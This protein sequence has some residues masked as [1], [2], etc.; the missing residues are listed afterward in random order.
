MRLIIVS[1]LSG[2]GKSVALSTLEDAGFYCIDNLPPSL[3]KD[4]AQKIGA[5]PFDT[6]ERIAVGIDA[7]SEA[8]DLR[9]LP[10]LLDQLSTGPLSTELLFLETDTSVLLRRFNETRRRHPLTR[11]GVALVEAIEMERS[12]LRG[13]KIRADLALDTTQLTGH[14]L[15]SKI[16]ERMLRA[17]TTD[18][19]VMFQSFGYKKGQ[20]GDT[21]FMFDVRCL[22][23]PYWAHELRD[24]TG[25]DPQV[26]AYLETHESV[27]RMNQMLRDFLAPW[28]EKFAAEQ[29]AYLTIS[30][31]CTGG[32][33]RSVYI[34]EQL[35]NHFRSILPNVSIRH[36]DS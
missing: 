18:M 29:R 5:A 22:P 13:I 26:A 36:R 24:L 25:R 31:G 23:N 33:H 17:D 6:Y 35:Y 12:I 20:P 30:V 4:L 28:V 16:R 21:D 3:L 9:A 2:S 7:R 8:A 27:R 10:Q 1:G 14:E 15:R 34:A 19:A 11:Q 32:Q